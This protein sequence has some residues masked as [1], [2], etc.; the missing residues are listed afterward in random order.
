MIVDWRKEI[1]IAFLVKQRVAELDTEGLWSFHFPEVAATELEIKVAEESLGE[2]IAAGYRAFLSFANGWQ[3]ILHATD[4]FGTIDLT[5]GEKLRKANELLESLEDLRPLCGLSLNEV[6]PIG[7]SQDDIDVI[8]IGRQ[9]SSKP[10]E[11]FWLAGQLIDSY[12]DFDEFFL[13]MVDYNRDQA[14]SFEEGR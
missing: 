13:A 14:R 2:R 8:A 4:I 9:N 5:C 1:S 6:M 10:G 12:P 3:G 11:V 7:V